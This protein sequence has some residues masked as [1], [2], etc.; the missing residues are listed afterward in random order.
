MLLKLSAYR[1][2]RCPQCGSWWKDQS[3]I[4]THLCNTQMTVLKF[5]RWT[6][7]VKP[8]NTNAAIDEPPG[9]TGGLQIKPIA[10]GAS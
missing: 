9:S 5:W 10:A 6:S 1:L 2:F 7:N 8:S 3:G 4:W